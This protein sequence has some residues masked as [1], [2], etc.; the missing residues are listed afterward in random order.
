MAIGRKVVTSSGSGKTDRLKEFRAAKKK[1]KAERPEPFNF[2]P[3]AC[4][5]ELVTVAE[6]R[7]YVS[8]KGVESIRLKL[9][10]SAKAVFDDLLPTGGMDK[11]MALEEHLGIEF[12]EAISGAVMKN[13][14][15]VRV[16]K[17]ENSNGIYYDKA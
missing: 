9:V 3:V 1:Q 13:L 16:T 6:A 8:K 15:D 4:D 17:G 11:I 12:D 10:D 14:G 7:L 2:I 5:K